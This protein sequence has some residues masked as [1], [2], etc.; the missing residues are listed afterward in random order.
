[1]TQIMFLMGRPGSGKSQ[2]AR[3]LK[4]DEQ[5]PAYQVERPDYLAGWSVLHIT[6]YTFLQRMHINDVLAG[7]KSP[8]F[9]TTGMGGFDVLD[10]NVLPLALQQVDAWVKRH[11]HA[12][13]TLILIEFARQEYDD[14]SVW[15]H[16]SDRVLRNSTF[17]Y[18]H[19]DLELCIQRVMRR[20]RS[21]F[22]PDDQYVSEAILRGYY[23]HSQ[24]N[25]PLAG[26]K[27]RFGEERVVAVDTNEKWSETWAVV[28]HFLGA[29][30]AR[31]STF[32]RPREIA[33]Q[34]P[35]V[36]GAERSPAPLIA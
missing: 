11:L 24:E 1:M 4:G 2:I 20:A 36:A 15:Q 7:V 25:G 8:R 12:W 10:F 14:Q 13:K 33:L 21:R 3:S 27:Q 5:W 31:S 34:L 26:L 35:R 29:I 28:E 17:L 32:P 6:D 30:S 19:A 16:F 23:G 22:Y 18:L 9:R